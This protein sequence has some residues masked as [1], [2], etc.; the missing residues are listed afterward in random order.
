MSLVDVTVPGVGDKTMKAVA[1]MYAFY[2]AARTALADGW[3]PGQDLPALYLSASA[4][5]LPILGNLSEIKDECK[6]SDAALKAVALAF[7]T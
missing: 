4:E 2:L 6:N 5:F 7:L 3:Q 1:S